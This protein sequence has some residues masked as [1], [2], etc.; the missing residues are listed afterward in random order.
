MTA[1][2]ARRVLAELVGTAL[3]VMA[4][5]GSG[6]AA[7]R[8]SPGDVG[9]QL[10]E[11]SL[12]TGAALVALILALQPISA[13]FN[14]LV[15]LAERVSGLV[16]TK[17]TAAL[18]GAQLA[19]GVLGALLANLRPARDKS[20]DPHARWGR[21]VARRSHR[22]RWSGASDLRRSPGRPA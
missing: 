2:L 12:A 8:L 17:E 10:L 16:G 19:G 21:S 9:L 7:S 18:I 11:N 20:L 4:I 6:I 14:P 3:L 22:H 1:V 13:A 5:I 15:T